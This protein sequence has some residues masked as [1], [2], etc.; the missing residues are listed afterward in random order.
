MIALLR[1]HKADIERSNEPLLRLSQS[2]V[3]FDTA[4]VEL[5]RLVRVFPRV[6]TCAAA[7]CGRIDRHMRI[8][9]KCRLG[10]LPWN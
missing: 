4:W 10:F 5:R 6:S 3:G 2:G 1:E 7:F 9:L 8:P